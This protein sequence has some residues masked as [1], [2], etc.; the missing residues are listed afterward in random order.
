MV[1][2]PVLQIRQYSVKYLLELHT[3]A[4]EVRM[5]LLSALLMVLVSSSPS[6]AGSLGTALQER[7]AP[8]P[9]ASLLS[10]LAESLTGALHFIGGLV[11]LRGVASLAADLGVPGAA[12][13]MEALTPSSG[14]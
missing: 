13:I 8:E 14:R 4:F 5:F 3:Q 2:K 10:R 7:P 12:A 11:P 6:S 1:D 9:L